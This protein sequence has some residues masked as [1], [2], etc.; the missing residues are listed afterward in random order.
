MAEA[1]SGP[2]SRSTLYGIAIVLFVYGWLSVNIYLPILPQLDSVFDTTTT[3]AR[4]TVTIFLVG[5]SFSQLVWGPLSDRFGRRPMLFTGLSIGVAGAVIAGLSDSL[6]TFAAG[7]FIEALGVGAGPVLGR[8]V[9][10]NSLERPRVAVAMAYVAIVVAIVPAVA[11]IVGGYVD[12]L[13][14]WRG[15]I[16]LLAVYGTALFLL[17][18]R[19]LPETHRAGQARLDVS[20]VIAEYAGMLRTRRYVGYGTIYGM[21][22]GTLV[23]YYAAAPFIFV[24]DLGFSAHAYGFLLLVNVAAYVLGATASRLA[25][26]RLGTERPIL[27]ALIAYAAAVVLFVV[28]ALVTT[29]N[30]V[31][32]LLPMSVFIFG[33]GM[34]SPAANAGAM[35]IFRDKAGAATAV[36]GFAIAVGGAVFSGVLSGIHITGLA[37]L[38]AY[39]GGSALISVALY[40]ALL[41]RTADP[42]DLEPARQ[43]DRGSGDAGGEGAQW[44][45]R[46]PSYR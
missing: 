23:G 22:F 29:M 30:A 10:T 45:G 12:L 44:T 6:T 13:F 1:T 14:G 26:P 4:L 3:A 28:L 34:V 46:T 11:P 41:R 24:R 21:A 37:G 5:F 39:V 38:G 2:M 20:G 33:T 40:V 16:F 27:F 9:L 36:V 31:S 43:N 17:C 18:F 19:L 15:V 35:T 8:S 7:R 42:P 25:V 32:V